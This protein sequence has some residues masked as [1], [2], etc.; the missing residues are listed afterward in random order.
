MAHRGR[1]F[2]PA[3]ITGFFTIHLED[4]PLKSGSTGAGLCLEAGARVKI[5]EGNPGI[6][7]NGTPTSLPTTAQIIPGHLGVEVELDVPLGCGFGASGA[8]TLATALALNPG[9]TLNRLAAQAHR[10]EVEHR[11]GLG[12][13]AAQT[14]GGAVIRTSPG[15]PF[16]LDRIP[17]P[18]LEI[19]WVSLG[20][21]KTSEILETT[22]TKEINRAGKKAL[23]NLL[24]KPTLQNLMLQSRTFAQTTGLLTPELQDILEAAEAADSL[25]SQAMLGNTIFAIPPMGKEENLI[26]TLK[27]FGSTG[28]SQINLTGARPL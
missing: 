23:K 10:A 3:H 16:K 26:E 20:K 17:T 4:N 8:I 25:A 24:K 6:R 2:A 14:L 27:T 13:V 19:C 7:V 18:P 12:D 15:Y 22:N 28:T 9:L 11:T 5:Q 21:L 1:A